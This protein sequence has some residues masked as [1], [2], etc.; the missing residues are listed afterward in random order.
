MAVSD[1]GNDAAAATGAGAGCAD[2][3]APPP[4]YGADRA[5]GTAAAAAAAAA[6][7]GSTAAEGGRTLITAPP[8]AA[9]A[10]ADSGGPPATVPAPSAGETV[11]VAAAADDSTVPANYDGKR[12]ATHPY[13]AQ[14]EDELQLAPGDI[15]FL[16][17]F[18][19]PEDA[20][21]GWCYGWSGGKRGLFP[22]N[23]TKLVNE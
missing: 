21:D 19:D 20:E 13:N 4:A 5:T 8:S 18:P 15:V 11:A 2:V 22:A 23:F 10:S 16:L 9:P 17:P 12:E 14:D 7:A 6:D 1:F 3:L